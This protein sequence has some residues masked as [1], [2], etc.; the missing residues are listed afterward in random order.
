MKSDVEIT[1]LFS[2][3]RC[4]KEGFN[5]N[6]YKELIIFKAKILDEITY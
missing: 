3:S 2:S 6:Q 4:Q 5:L 1:K